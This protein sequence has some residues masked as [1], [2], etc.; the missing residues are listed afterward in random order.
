M[1]FNNTTVIQDVSSTQSPE[2]V[3][4]IME[5]TWLAIVRL[6]VESTIALAGVVGNFLVCFAIT[7]HRMLNKFPTNTYIRN[8]AMGDFASLLV[9]FPLGIVREQFAYWPLGEFTCRYIFPLSDIF[10]GV[11]V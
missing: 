5:P 3:D 6:T 7:R 8:L 1:P 9:S 4:I 10:F 11:S 2:P